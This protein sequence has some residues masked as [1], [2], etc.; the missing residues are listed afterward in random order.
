MHS[1]G[2]WSATHMRKPARS[3]GRPAMRKPAR[4]KGGTLNLTKA[5]TSI[6]EVKRHITLTVQNVMNCRRNVLRLPQI[7]AAS[8]ARPYPV[9]RTDQAKFTQTSSRK[10]FQ[11]ICDPFRFRPYADHCVNMVGSNVQGMEF[12]LTLFA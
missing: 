10:R 12:I 2:V 4:S 3:K 6:I 9:V 7:S 5:K 8:A 1:T 11:R